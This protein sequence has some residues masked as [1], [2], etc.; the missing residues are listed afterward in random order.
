MKRSEGEVPR[1]KTLAANLA[2][3]TKDSAA[4]VVPRE[5]HFGSSISREVGR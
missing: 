1:E 2:L 5:K 4:K 3:R